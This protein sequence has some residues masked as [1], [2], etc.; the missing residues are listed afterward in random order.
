MLALAGEQ[1]VADSPNLLYFGV[2]HDKF[3]IGK[4]I[5][6]GEKKIAERK[7]FN[8][9]G[10]PG[11]QRLDRVSPERV[12]SYLEGH[13]VEETDTENIHEKYFVS[14]KI[15]FGFGGRQEE[16]KHNFV[17][18][19]YIRSDNGNLFSRTEPMNPTT[20]QTASNSYDTIL[21]GFERRI[22]QHDDGRFTLSPSDRFESPLREDISKEF[23]LDLASSTKDRL[24]WKAA[25]EED[26]VWN[27]HDKYLSQMQ[28]LIDARNNKGPLQKYG[29]DH[30]KE[31]LSKEWATEGMIEFEH[32]KL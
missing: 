17:H 14:E 9:N 11:V 30:N 27:R 7:T 19:H 23:V 29:R 10:Q 4:Q 13:F 8:S 25:G 5:E 31:T 2:V 28:D 22:V 6:N 1:S 20:G 3:D 18:H 32:R 15:Y 16:R 21:A 24:I 26:L 12:K